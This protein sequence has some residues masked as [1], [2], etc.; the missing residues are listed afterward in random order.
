MNNLNSLND[1]NV[2]KTKWLVRHT[3]ESGQG[4]QVWNRR[5]KEAKTGFPLPRE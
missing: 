5:I 1:W 2:L 3:R 4:I